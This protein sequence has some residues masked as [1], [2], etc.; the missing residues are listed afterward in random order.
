MPHVMCLLNPGLIWPHSISDGLIDI[1]YFLIPVGLLRLVRSRRDLAYHWLF[2]LMRCS[3][4]IV[5][6]P[7]CFRDALGSKLSSRGGGQSFHG[8]R[9]AGSGVFLDPAHSGHR[10]FPSPEQWRSSNEEFKAEI[11]QRKTAEAAM[12]A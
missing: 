10:Y 6:R 8:Y 7:M 4:L 11:S 3:E 5:A 12:L 9:L 2:L 1:A